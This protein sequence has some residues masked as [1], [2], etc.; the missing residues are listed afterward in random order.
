LFSANVTGSTYQY[1]DNAGPFRVDPSGNGSVSTIVSNT[2]TYTLYAMNPSGMTVSDTCTLYT[3]NAV[4]PI[5]VLTPSTGTYNTIITVTIS[6]PGYPGATIY[7]TTDESIP[8]YPVTGTTTLYTGPITITGTTP[9]PVTYLP[10]EQINAIAV[11]LTGTFSAPSGVG[12]AVY[13]VN[14]QAPTPVITPASGSYPLGTII[15]ISVDPS[16]EP[17]DVNQDGDAAYIYYTTDGSTPSG[18]AYGDANGTS[19]ACAV[20]INGNG[21]CTFPLAGGATVVNAIATAVGYSPSPVAT[22]DYNVTVTFGMAVAPQT[23]IIDPASTAGSVSVTV[24][25]VNGYVGTVNLSCS[26]LPPGDAC[27]FNPASV[28]VT[29]TANGK[30]TLT[31]S[32]GLNSHNNSFPLLP[33]GAT[34]A[35]ALCFF[36]LRKRRSLQLIVLL[37]A[38]VIGLSLFTG[39]GTPGSVPNSVSVTIT[40]TDS[41]G[42]PV[43]STNLQLIQMQSQ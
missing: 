11:D 41:S 43:A 38:S 21:P 17:I 16:F 42:A 36:G 15:T 3:A 14:S 35:V 6:D 7:Y 19:I 40:G 29:T 28:A 25:S 39:C 31:I 1:V 30:S 10:G 22:A 18:D 24:S 33:G 20:G 32:A 26:G 2:Q 23:L 27:T 34:L 13:V 8:T 9:D 37:A 12:S 5:P 4:L